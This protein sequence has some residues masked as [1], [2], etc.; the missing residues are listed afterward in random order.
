MTLETLETLVKKR[1]KT[2]GQVLVGFA[3]SK[4]NMKGWGVYFGLVKFLRKGKMLQEATYDYG[5][6]ILTKLLLQVPEALSFIRS[7]VENQI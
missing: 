2:F 5:N 7:I 3:F 4:H 1:Q 6:F